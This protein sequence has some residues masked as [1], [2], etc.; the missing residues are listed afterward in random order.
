MSFRSG[1]TQSAILTTRLVDDPD[2]MH[3]VEDSIVS[4]SLYRIFPEN[5][6]QFDFYLNSIGNG[7]VCVHTYYSTEP[8][9]IH[10]YVEKDGRYDFIGDL[11]CDTGVVKYKEP[12]KGAQALYVLCAYC[13]IHVSF[14]LFS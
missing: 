11:D 2:R 9:Q 7:K 10:L 1:L 5:P 6:L 3:E 8:M 14:R 13:S 12:D 4:N